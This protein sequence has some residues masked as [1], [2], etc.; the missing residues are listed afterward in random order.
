MEHAPFIWAAYAAAAVILTWNALAPLW[1]KRRAVER[2]R[3]LA[4]QEH[5]DDSHP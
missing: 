5:H 3:S 4:R 1:R 2:I